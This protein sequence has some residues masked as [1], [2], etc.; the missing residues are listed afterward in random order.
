MTDRFEAEMAYTRNMGNY[1]SA[2]VV[3][4]YASDARAG[5]DAQALAD[6]VKDFVQDRLLEDFEGTEQ[7]LA[8]ARKAEKELEKAG[9]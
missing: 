8:A 4:R 3:F 7:Q 6:R 2:R 5:E 9:K 1:E